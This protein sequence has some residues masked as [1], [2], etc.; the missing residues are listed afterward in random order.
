MVTSMTPETLYRVVF[1]VA[2]SNP[3]PPNGMLRVT[4]E[5]YQV[6]YR[7]KFYLPS[8][9]DADGEDYPIYFE[10]HDT[11]YGRD[12]FFLS[13]EIAD[14]EYTQ[15]GILTLTDVTIESHP[16]FFHK[17]F[18]ALFLLRIT[19]IVRRFSLQRLKNMSRFS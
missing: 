12:R 9:S 3:S 5:D 14:F 1:T 15:G 16:F 19:K 8:T 18:I 11:V 6:S 7:L 17:K 13:F 4:S 2:S 10:S